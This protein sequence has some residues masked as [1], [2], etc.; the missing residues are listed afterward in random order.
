L[1]FSVPKEVEVTNRAQHIER[2]SS[3]VFHSYQQTVTVD[4][5]GFNFGIGLT[6]GNFGLGNFLSKSRCKIWYG[7]RFIYSFIIGRI[8]DKL[9]QRFRATGRS[10]YFTS[11]YSCLAMPYPF[12]KQVKFLLKVV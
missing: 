2:S 9:T 7:I 1:T 5:G 11:G 3:E 10:L 12:L 6:V 4:I 8:R